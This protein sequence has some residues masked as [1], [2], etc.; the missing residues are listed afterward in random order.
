MDKSQFLKHEIFM[1]YLNFSA[2][3]QVAISLKNRYIHIVCV[4][5]RK[6]WTIEII[7]MEEL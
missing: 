7:N 3:M 5:V 2:F 1:N 4:L 6:E